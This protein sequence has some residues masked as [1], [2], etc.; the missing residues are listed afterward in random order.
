MIHIGFTGTR[1]GMTQKQKVKLSS[2]LF[3]VCSNDCV[4]HHGDCIGADQEAAE[5]AKN[6][7]YSLVCHPPSN[8][9]SQAFVVSNKTRSPKPYIKRNHDIVDE[10]YQLIATPKSNQEELRSGTWAT[11]R[12]ARKTGIQVIIIYP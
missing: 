6:L 2:L 5:I 4:F 9:K 11:V 12:Y 8:P 10:C 3:A 1:N 7:G